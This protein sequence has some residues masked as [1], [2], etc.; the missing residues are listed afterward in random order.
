ML[1]MDLKHSGILAATFMASKKRTVGGSKTK[2]GERDEYTSPMDGMGLRN[3]PPSSKPPGGVIHEN[4]PIKN[5]PSPKTLKT[6][7]IESI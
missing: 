6:R 4:L 3:L 1:D 2:L 7:A 5:S